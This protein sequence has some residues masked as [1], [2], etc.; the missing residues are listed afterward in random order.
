MACKPIGAIWL[1]A[2]RKG[3]D[4]VFRVLSDI[5]PPDLVSY[6]PNV[7]TGRV[8]GQDGEVV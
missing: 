3:D 7:Y 6:D 1:Q 8:Y 5:R 2:I 4:I